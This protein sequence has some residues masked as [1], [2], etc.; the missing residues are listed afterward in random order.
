M[1]FG[2][3]KHIG[4]IVYTPR[5]RDNHVHPG[6]EYELFYCDGNWKS[7]GRVTASSD[8]ILYKGL[9]AGTLYI[10]NNLSRGKDIR[11]FSYD[12]GVQEWDRPKRKENLP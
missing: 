4:K 12:N 2:E 6:D 3:P 9:P 1:H 7:A 10:L 11:V 8:S 5:N